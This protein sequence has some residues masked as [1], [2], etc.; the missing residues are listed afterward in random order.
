MNVDGQAQV[1]T[2]H[3]QERKIIYSGRND[4]QHH[5]AV[6]LILRKGLRNCLMKSVSEMLDLK[7]NMS[8]LMCYAPTNNA[9]NEEKENFYSSFQA[10]I[11]KISRHDLLI[12]VEERKSRIRICWT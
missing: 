2:T 12:I 11:Q 6:A 1:T 3:R 7:G 4:D 9:D 10:D 5:G 8:I